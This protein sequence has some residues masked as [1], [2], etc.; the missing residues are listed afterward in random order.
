MPNMTNSNQ[1]F[2][3][4][5]TEYSDIVLAVMVVAI[6]AIL[7][8]PMPPQFLDFLLAFNITISMVILLV[9][10]Y[11]T[12]PLDL[13][14]FPGLLLIITLFRLSLNVAS[15]RLILGK[16]YAGEVISSFGNFVVGGN[17]V[18]GF[19]IFAILVIIQFVVI[20]K[21]AGRIAEVAA[22]FT[23]DAMP[24]KQMAID[25]DLNAGLISEADAR[26]RRTEISKEADFYGAM[27]GASKFVRGDAIAGIL[28]TL[29]NVIGGIVIGVVQKGMPAGQALTTYTLLTV[30]DGLVTQIPA[31][32]VSTSA[33]IVVTR[34]ASDSNL[35]KDLTSQI[36]AQ[37]RAILVAAL[38]LASFGIVPGMP[39]LPFIMLGGITGIIGYTSIQARKKKEQEATVI[40][41]S[42][43][44]P[45]QEK[46]EEYLKVDPMEV[47]I[48][49][50]LIPLV[51]V[52]QGNDLLD[53]ISM[54]R[55]QIASEMGF[56]VPPIRIRDNIQL[57]PNE[58]QIKIRGHKISSSL[59]YPGQHLAINPGFVTEQVDGPDVLEPAFG[60]NAKWVSDSM[61]AIA[62]KRGY[63][64]VEPAAVMATHLTE[65]IRSHAAEFITRQETANLI[66]NI[67]AEH[68]ALV[69]EV[70][71]GLVG[72][73]VVQKILQNLLEERIPIIDLPSIIETIGDF[74]SSTKEPDIL[75]EYCR[76][77]LNRTITEQYLN[78]VGGMTVMTLDPELEQTIASAIQT[79]KH[80]LILTLAPEVAAQINNSVRQAVEEMQAQGYTPV[81][82]VSPNIRL[83]LKRFTRPIESGLAVISYNELLPEIEVESIKTVRLTDG[84]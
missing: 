14:V 6:L 69:E 43:E 58:Y 57:K 34:A 44:I 65:I 12:R 38:I 19:I 21:G 50:A 30:G 82:L 73:G 75:T 46:M 15:T 26:K 28:I 18:V 78:S 64:V 84:N 11:I 62:E 66:T 27:D 9:T 47:E 49:Y 70:V 61:R 59:L 22:R 52:A 1:S 77:G 33:G 2:I 76:H 20:T 71:P 67:K 31:L 42:K 80:G 8:L 41:E 45:P 3:T 60:L 13:S 83:V 16:A 56:L 48:G 7:I 79:T 63:T 35:G 54:I 55:R 72:V 53:R 36:T 81:L 29:I 40:Q 24:G 4:R 74:A 5:L 39:T 37:P 32:I 25:A 23:L 68:S 17:Y 51:D 10:M